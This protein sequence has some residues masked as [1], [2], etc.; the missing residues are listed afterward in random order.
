MA[1]LGL[2]RALSTPLVVVTDA[3]AYMRSRLRTNFDSLSALQ[4]RR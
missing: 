3:S 1:R 4:V 2:D